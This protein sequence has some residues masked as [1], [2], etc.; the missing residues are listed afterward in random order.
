MKNCSTTLAV[1]A[2]LLGLAASAH[3]QSNVTISGFVDAGVYRNFDKSKNV[4][5]IQRSYLA[6]SGNE[7]LGGGMAATFRLSHRF[8]IESGGI[9]SGGK[10]FWHDEAT[11]GLKGSFGSIRLGRALS[12]VW[13]QDWAF[14]PW[15]NFNRIASPAWHFWHYYAPTDRVS[16]GGNAEYGRVNSGVFYDSPSFGGLTV[17]LSGSPE[18]TAA[19]GNGRSRAGSLVYANG[20]VTAMLGIERNGSD[21]RDVFLGGKYGFGALT[22]MG[23]YN[24]SR[25]NGTNNEAKVTSFGATYAMG[26]TTLKASYGQLN[27][28]HGGDDRDFIGLGA[29]YALSKRTTVYASLGHISPDAAS[30]QTAYGVGIAHAF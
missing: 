14:D 19:P 30:S 26:A 23:A 22:V 16:N 27:L 12:A 20:P 15:G 28:N 8:D 29:D 13:S 1:G 5:T 6:F 24:E 17:H 25:Q 10:P 18:R 11:V 2:A 7:D 9:E 4:G 3:A 21:D